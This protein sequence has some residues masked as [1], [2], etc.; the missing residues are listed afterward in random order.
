M[1][2]RAT[3]FLIAAGASLAPL[4]GIADAST[5][6]S[7]DNSVVVSATGRYGNE[8]WIAEY[9]PGGQ[10]VGEKRLAT[11]A[12]DVFI[13]VL[14][15]DELVV[16]FS[17]LQYGTDR[18]NLYVWDLGLRGSK[19]KLLFSSSSDS[20]SD[21]VV[22][23]RQDRVVMLA[24]SDNGSYIEVFDYGKSIRRIAWQSTYVAGGPWF[25]EL[26]AVTGY[27]FSVVGSNLSG[28][29]ARWTQVDMRIEGTGPATQSYVARSGD[30]DIEAFVWR[31]IA[32]GQF[33]AMYV[34]RSGAPSYG[35]GGIENFSNPGATPFCSVVTTPSSAAVDVDLGEGKVP[36]SYA[37][38]G[39]LLWVASVPGQVYLQGSRIGASGRP[40]LGPKVPL[41]SGQ[42]RFATSGSLAETD[43]VAYKLNIRPA[44]LR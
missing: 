38:G 14:D 2:K 43:R 30:G 27:E 17:T 1:L 12:R 11:A 36:G 34:P 10:V 24:R 40:E 39:T 4:T 26:D 41:R 35:C 3:V 44:T 7:K 18:Y 25:S 33:L 23:E 16:A 13:S 21:A 42:A 28:G 8:M 9:S 37:I 5:R 20:V 31:E 6:H 15:V 22:Q 32:L 19:P 29:P